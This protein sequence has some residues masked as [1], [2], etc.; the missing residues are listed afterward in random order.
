EG[1]VGL[2]VRPDV[3]DLHGPLRPLVASLHGGSLLEGGGAAGA[4]WTACPRL[5]HV[6]GAIK[7]VRFGKGRGPGGGTK[8]RTLHPC[9]PCTPLRGGGA[10]AGL[11]GPGALTPAPR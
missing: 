8:S 5:Y 7:G 9:R 6:R 3:H 10:L 2:L 4:P 1:L 11:R